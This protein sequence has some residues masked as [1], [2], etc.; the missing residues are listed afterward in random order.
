MRLRAQQQ[1]LRGASKCPRGRSHPLNACWPVAVSTSAPPRLGKPAPTTQKLRQLPPPPQGKRSSCHTTNFSCS[2]RHMSIPDLAARTQRA[3]W[4]SNV[5][6]LAVCHASVL[7]NS[8]QRP[9]SHSR[10]HR[11]SCLRSRHLPCCLSSSPNPILPSRYRRHLLLP[12]FPFSQ[13]YRQT[14]DV[15]STH[16]L[17]NYRTT[18][19]Q[20]SLRHLS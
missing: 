13:S 12:A 19:L 9:S 1:H 15:P 3:L 17:Q 10:S 6:S 20:N 16:A 8:A 5:P 2:S 18:E 7:P 14:L 11:R 4:A